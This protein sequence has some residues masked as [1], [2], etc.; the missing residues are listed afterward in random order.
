MDQSLTAEQ[1]YRDLVQAY[2]KP[3]IPPGAFTVKTFAQ[4]TG[5]GI[6]QAY[7]I[8]NAQVAAGTLGRVNDGRRD[9]YFFK[10]VI[11]SE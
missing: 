6:K 7:E 4:D 11:L 5:T 2:T 8:L 10:T 3:A 1:L 9:W